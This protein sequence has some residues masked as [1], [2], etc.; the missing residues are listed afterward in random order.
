MFGGILKRRSIIQI[1]I[2]SLLLS[3]K[4]NLS[5][6]SS[7]IQAGASIPK[8]DTYSLE[9]LPVSFRPVQGK[10]LLIHVWKP[11]DTGSEGLIKDTLILYRRFHD[12]GLDALSICC[13]ASEDVSADM[14]ERWQIDWPQVMNHEETPSLTEQLGIPAIPSRLIV[15]RDGMAIAIDPMGDD[16]HARMAQWL[17]VSLDEAPMPEPPREAD[18]SP[19]LVE[20]DFREERSPSWN[21]GELSILVMNPADPRRMLGN[22][23]ERREAEETIRIFR[24][25]NLALARYREENRGEM[26][27]WLS[28]LYPDYLANDVDLL[29]PSSPTTLQKYVNLADRNV[30]TSFTYELAP[31]EIQGQNNREQKKK[32]LEIFGDK[33]PVVRCFHF[34]RPLCLTYGGEI[35]FM[36]EDWEKI[37]PRG[38]SLNDPGAKVRRQLMQIGVAV[39]RFVETKG[40]FPQEPTELVSEYLPNETSLVCEVTGQPFE[41]LHAEATSEQGE[42]VPL[43]RARGVLEKDRVLNLSMGGE[44]W[45]S[46][47]DWKSFLDSAE[48]SSNP[49]SIRVGSGEENDA[50]RA[51]HW[52]DTPLRNES[53]VDTPEAILP[54]RGR[55]EFIRED[56]QLRMPNAQSTPTALVFFPW[57]DKGEIC[58]RARVA[59]GKEGF[60]IIFGYTSPERF[61]QMSLGEFD[62]Q[63]LA[64]RKWNDLVGSNVT[65]VS[66]QVPFIV[67]R[68][69]WVDIRV[70]VDDESKIAQC[71]I[72][73]KL[74]LDYRSEESLAGRLG[75][76]TWYTAVDFE[77]IVIRGTISVPT[78]DVVTNVSSQDIRFL[79]SEIISPGKSPKRLEEI[80]IVA[81]WDEKTKEGFDIY[82]VSW[83][84]P[85]FNA[86]LKS[87]DRIIGIQEQ[88]FSE[89]TVDIAGKAFAEEMLNAMGDFPWTFVVRPAG[90]SDIVKIIVDR[91]L[92]KRGDP[93]A[94]PMITTL[95]EGSTDSFFLITGIQFP[96]VYLPID[97]PESSGL[98][99]VQ[100]ENATDICSING[101]WEIDGNRICQKNVSLNPTVLIFSPLIENGE[102]RL[103]AKPMKGR[104]GIRILFGYSRHDLPYHVWN[105]GGRSNTVTVVEEWRRVVNGHEIEARTN[106]ADFYLSH[107]QWHDIRLLIDADQGIAFGFI[108][109]QKI[110]EY[111]SPKSLIGRFGVGTGE[112]TAS[113]QNI[114]IEGR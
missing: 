21:G 76:G 40:K 86:G 31:V 41:Y 50:L 38:K 84:S 36:D 58:F 69:E 12:K 5:A 18:K 42:I 94:P 32:M 100:I 2:L 102:I 106:R 92:V 80:G 57:I 101:E 51:R 97:W 60:K 23:E 17:G 45:E 44:I 39:Q 68:D 47:E 3:V 109:D 54:L 22:R 1:V 13:D 15:D 99:T 82:A 24:K 63:F 103:Q 108:N 96:V 62:N 65:T 107:D 64:V 20:G 46:G 104:E 48:T 87:G 66:E 9:G 6:V 55:W 7:P 89:K 37:L 91:S 34:K 33:I 19:S 79:E 61:F 110:M 59:E 70:T 74:M 72:N 90:Q 78:P 8:I 25:I 88:R 10:L 105:I 28:D 85:A 113:F 43:F 98:G 111:Q 71:F 112:T 75:L 11:Q 29:C 4:Y 27:D 49:V 16:L 73:G 81:Q 77:S 52:P 67:P 56:K 93:N 83:K 30:P 35:V 14:A 114:E 53:P 26:P 95:P